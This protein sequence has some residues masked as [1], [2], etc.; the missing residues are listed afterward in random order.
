MSEREEHNELIHRL[1]ER[2]RNHT[3]PYKDGAWERFAATHS[4]RRRKLWPYYSSA[5]AVLLA[6]VGWYWAAQYL[7]ETPPLPQMVQHE[8]G[9]QSADVVEQGEEPEELSESTGAEM[10]RIHPAVSAPV[11]GPTTERH[12]RPGA[13]TQP[14][15]IPVYAD[16]R[17]VDQGESVSPTVLAVT[18]A[19]TIIA[20][21]S[22]PH[23]LAVAVETEGSGT[24][25]EPYAGTLPKSDN[26]VEKWDLG[27]MVSPSLTSEAVNIGGGF[28]V[29]YHISDKF[30]IGSGI[31]VA[32]LGVGENPNYQPHYDNQLPNDVSAG[33]PYFDGKSEMALDYKREVSLTSSVVTL[34]IPLDIRYE[35]AKGFYTSVGVSYVAVLDERRTGH[36]VDR[37][38]KNTF[39]SSRL[40]TADRL[41]ATEFVYSSEKI[42]AK[43]LQGKGY[44]GFM[45]FSVGKKLPISSQL[46]L[47]I[48]PYFKLPIGR[49]SKEE[50]NFTNGGIRIVTGF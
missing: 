43:P 48:E 15:D 23:P 5:A 33:G 11:P 44:A 35:M 8:S 34:D 30:S 9:A 29:A 19:D 27:L 47:S 6:A 25:S 40:S 42:A 18:A 26:E 16:Y 31:S 22:E 21:A 50:M 10:T 49:L 45:N 2:L 28:A 41:A 7:S 1:A 14:A 3:E 17:E 32:Q 38:N 12:P 46:F 13:V 20:D 24:R 4:K 39:A 36:Y 37:L